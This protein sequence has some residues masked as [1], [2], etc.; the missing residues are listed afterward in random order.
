MDK[1]HIVKIGGKVIENKD[2]LISFLEDFASLEESK[3]LIHGGGNEANNISKKIGLEI[4]IEGGRRITDSDSLDLITMVYA[5]KINKRIVSLL[6]SISCNAL[7]ISGA[8]GN[9]YS[10]IKR[11]IKDI[12]FGFVG[13]L[14]EVNISF[15]TGLIKQNIVPV[16]CSVTHDRKGQLL[17][18]NA[19]TIAASIA[20]ALSKNFKVILTYCFEKMGVLEDINDENSVIPFIDTKKYHELKNTETISQGM[21]P[22]LHNCFES[23]EKG[24]QEIRIGNSSIFSQKNQFTKIKK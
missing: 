11:P 10:A 12:D 16:C 22:K 18:T 1:L 8:D 23:L 20:S 5:G 3:I 2:S 6:Q 4:K 13:D 24:V 15:F 7:G 19:D 21:M 9:A 14:T 17:N